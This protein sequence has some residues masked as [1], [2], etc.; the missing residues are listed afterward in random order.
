[1]QILLTSQAKSSAQ[2]GESHGSS[3]SSINSLISDAP[4][5]QATRN[6]IAEW[7]ESNT[8]IVD[9]TKVLKALHIQ[10]IHHCH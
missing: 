4:I 8:L 3:S 1:M 6:Q 9:Q 2:A 5:L 7:N 10:N